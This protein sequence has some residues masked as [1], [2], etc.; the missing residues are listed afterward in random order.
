[1]Y[2]IPAKTY[3][4]NFFSK[5]FNCFIIHLLATRHDPDKCSVTYWDYTFE[6]CNCTFY[7][8]AVLA[9]MVS[10]EIRYFCLNSDTSVSLK[11]YLL[12]TRVNFKEYICLLINIRLIMGRETRW[13]CSTSLTPYLYTSVGKRH[14]FKCHLHLVNPKLGGRQLVLSYQN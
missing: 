7:E 12:I 13:E 3:S 6:G 14:T 10:N 11:W 8:F 2:F 4:H 5:N 9:G 1:M